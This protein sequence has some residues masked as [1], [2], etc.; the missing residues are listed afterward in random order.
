MRS[1]LENPGPAL[2]AAV[3]EATVE[4]ALAED[5]DSAALD[6]EADL[7]TSWIVPA[8]TR[9]R[10]SIIARQPG[11]VA[12]LD[13]A[14][15]V[16]H[17]LDPDIAFT[18]RIQ[19]GSPVNRG[20]LLAR[21]EGPARALLT[22]ERTALNFL[23]HLSGIATLTRAYVEAIAGTSARITE[24][25]KTTPGLRLLEKYAVRLGGGVNHRLGLYDAVLI[26]ENHAAPLGGVDRAVEAARRVARQHQREEVP[27]YAEARDLDEVARV[28]AARPDRI[29]LDNMPLE[30]MREAV[31]LIRREA[32]QIQIE[33]TGNV[34][35]DNVRQTA[36]TGVDLIS[37]GALTHS[38]PALD[39][40]MLFDEAA[41]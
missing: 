4:Q 24:T 36:E 23:Q 3:I 41:G 39:L 29:M 16:F 25:R 33:A 5:L 18:A 15:R 14:Q 22:G 1:N 8:S 12:G 19:E 13:A 28:L 6:P 21:L 35:L 30:M 2:P 11:V 10:A 20:D 26:K 7:T 31:P 17:R 32:P 27:I 34:T 38:A 9:A 40:S 37:I